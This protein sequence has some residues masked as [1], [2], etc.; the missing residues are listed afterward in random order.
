MIGSTHRLRPLA[1]AALAGL[2]AVAAPVPA[3][4]AVEQTVEADFNAQSFAPVPPGQPVEVRIYKTT[5]GVEDLERR[6]AEIV[7]ARGWTVV[8][9]GGALAFSLEVTGDDPIAPL[10][11]DGVLAVEG[12][13]SS[14]D[15]DERIYSRLKLYST[16]RSSVLTGTQSP[17]R[18]AHGGGTRLQL[19]VT[20]LSNGQ[21][22]WQGWA[23]LDPAGRPPEVAA[24]KLLPMMMDAVGQT[25]RGESR[26]VEFD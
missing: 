23:V 11:E 5:G 3:A 21:R 4:L 9:D 22:L 18:L 15:S 19:D 26:L 2:L 12:F 16:T 8:E 13:Q 17:D 14:G 25:V 24:E 10:P 1:A 6:V 7:R 20:D